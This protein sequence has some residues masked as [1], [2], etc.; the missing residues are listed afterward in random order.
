MRILIIDDNEDKYN[1]IVEAVESTP[2][3]G[4]A[5]ISWANDVVSAKKC[6]KRQQFDLAI[7]DIALP[8]RIGGKVEV[9]AG[10]ELLKEVI[11][12]GILNTPR[13]VVG[14]T[15][16]KEVYESST[17]AFDEDLWSILHYDRAS[18]DWSEKLA[19]KIRHI[20][21]VDNPGSKTDVESNRFDI[22]ILAALRD[23]LNAV[24]ANGWEWTA[25]DYP[26]DSTIYYSCE[27]ETQ[28][29]G[30]K[31]IV[32]AKSPMM[33]MSSAAVLT[34]KTI[35]SFTPEYVFLAGICAG[36]SD[37]VEL[38]DLIAGRTVWDYGAGKYIGEKSKD[39][40]IIPA[41][42]EPAPY[43]LGIGASLR[44]KVERLETNEEFFEQLHKNFQGKKPRSMSK[45]FIGPF[46]S[47]AAVVADKELFVKIQSQQDRKLLGIDMEAFGA[48]Y[49]SSEAIGSA[50]QFLCLKCVTDYADVD[51]GDDVREYACYM[52]AM[53]ISKLCQ[54][55]IEYST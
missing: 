23:E 8:V 52:S 35:S 27:V 28:K 48:M 1:S 46:A 13:H 41:I 44:G 31:K 36:D 19:R 49:A 38:G 39:G 45:L 10:I 43:H 24:L 11:G 47:G 12:R 32:A 33:G 50:P 20:D 9:G 4:K 7:L 29:H 2:I 21:V 55:L 6:M 54:D 42:F 14:L 26:G 15:G 3:K 16:F 5:E 22:A 30:M 37:E 34:S 40:E 17:S 51:K 18:V 25:F 53:A